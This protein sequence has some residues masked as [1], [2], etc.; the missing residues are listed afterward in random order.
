MTDFL[1]R[2]VALA[3]PDG[4]ITGELFVRDGKIADFGNALGAPD[5]AEI[6]EAEGAILAPGLVDIRDHNY[7]RFTGQQARHR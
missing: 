2:K 7:R 4:L 6:I 3:T 5:G 1:F